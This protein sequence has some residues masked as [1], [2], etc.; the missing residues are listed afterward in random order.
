M[1][2]YI[3][4]PR[5]Q[6]P[7]AAEVDVLVIGGGPAGASAAICS[8]RQGATTMLVERYGYLGGLA[9]G[10][11]VIFLDDMC[12]DGEITVAGIVDEFQ[13]RL[14]ELGGLVRPPEG[15]WF[16]KSTE[17][18][19]KWYWWGLLEGVGRR[20][21]SPVSYEAIFDVEI[22]KQVLFQMVVD[23]GVKLRLHSWCISAI[24]E[25]NEVQGA[26]FVS[27]S[28]LYAVRAK[29]VVD[30]TGDGDVF[31]SAGAEF[32]HGQYLISVPHFMAN[33]DTEK[34]IKYAAEQPEAAKKLDREVRRIYGITWTP[35]NRLTLI[36]GVVWCDCPHIKG[37]DALNVEHLT[38]LE[39]EGRRR[40]WK[41]LRFVR[42]NYPGFE[43][44]Y[45]V[46]TSDQ[47]GVRQGRLLVGEYIMTRGDIK[48]H[49]RFPDTVGRGGGYYY[50]YRCFVPKEINNLL[51][52][53]RHVSMEP[54][55]QKVAREIAPCMVTGQ[56]VGTAAALALE[57]NV[58]VRDV[59]VRELQKRLENQGV[60]L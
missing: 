56:A 12:F 51:V 32:I 54:S 20:K 55:A 10:A 19:E 42:E 13:E 43:N 48:S 7:I 47:I 4:F 60:L 5:T 49:K 2:K 9:T 53:G 26:I 58:R 11:M 24:T 3:R 31:A 52:A 25:G 22:G 6:V 39:I 45:V 16:K 14:H 38:E 17:L 15:E 35:W 1:D 18:H 23:A 40:I 30:T 57:R 21:P 41:A 37:Y 27:K 46:R 34:Y 36:P 28:G 50:P 59:N 29:V 44:A 33:V 8:A